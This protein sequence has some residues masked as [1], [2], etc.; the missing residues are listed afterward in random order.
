MSRTLIATSYTPWIPSMFFSF[1][2]RTHART[3]EPSIAAGLFPVKRRRLRTRQTRR[4]VAEHVVEAGDLVTAE[5]PIA[6]VRGQTGLREHLVRDL[7]R[8]AVR[9]A[10][11]DEDGL[12]PSSAGLLE[13]LALVVPE[14]R[15]VPEDALP[16]LLPVRPERVGA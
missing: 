8:G 4:Q 9:E 2:A 16:A 5:P 15:T 7:R 6:A 1:R 3:V 11:A 12:A 14:R 13:R 10:V